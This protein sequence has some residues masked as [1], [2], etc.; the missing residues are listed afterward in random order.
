MLIL[1]FETS[2]DETSAAV[3]K[4]GQQVL[5][6]VIASSLKEHR[7]YGGII[8]EIASRRQLEF[9]NT[10]TK[11][12][13]KGSGVDLRHIDGLAV[14]HTPGLIGSL[15]VGLSYVKALSF[16]LTIPLME[17]DHIK[18]HLYAPFLHDA[19]A[20]RN[21]K[22]PR[23]PAVGLIASGGHTSLYRINHLTSFRLLGQTR[24]DAVG[25]AFDKVSRILGLGYPGGPIID[26]VAKQQKESRMD[27]SCARLPHSHD[28][29]FSGIKTAVLYHVQKHKK[30]LTNKDIAEIA[31]AF[32]KNVVA[33]LVEKCIRACRSQKVNSLIL[34]GGVTANSSLRTRLLQEGTKNNIDVFL[35]PMNLCIDNAAM[36]AGLAFH[37]FKKA[38]T[39]NKKEKRK[40]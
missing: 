24:D 9:I 5:S 20:P 40:V 13:L 31:H 4:N 30:N 25:E 29:S 16:S 26:K 8:P 2:C 17:V 21:K 38:A 6:N 37:Q 33:V 12:C 19:K 36:I 22:I 39:I 23:L 34:G 11:R 7:R 1:G 28:F 14:T 18:A 10:V 35:P 3:V 15:L 32:Q 27:F